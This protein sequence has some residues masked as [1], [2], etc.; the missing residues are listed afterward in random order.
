MFMKVLSPLV[1]GHEAVGMRSRLWAGVLS[2][3]K[4]A[5]VVF[6]LNLWFAVHSQNV[7]P[8]RI[9]EL[10]IIL[11]ESYLVRLSDRFTEDLYI[12]LAQKNILE[13][14]KTTYRKPTDEENR[15]KELEQMLGVNPDWLGKSQ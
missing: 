5:A 2:L 4:L 12:W 8:A 6:G 10:P 13:Y 9:T 11:Q 14:R 1:I 3:T 7:H 15:K